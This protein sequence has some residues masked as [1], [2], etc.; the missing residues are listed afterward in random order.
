MEFVADS[1]QVDCVT[2]FSFLRG[3]SHAEELIERAAALGYC[4]LA[5]TDECSIAGVARAHVAAKESGLQ[6]IVGTEIR[7]EDGMKVVLL[8]TDRRSYGAISSLITT[9]RRRAPKGTYSLGRK[10]LESVAGTGALMLWVPSENP[11]L[12]EALWIKARFPGSAWIA[13]ELHCG[14]N[15]RSRLDSFKRLSEEAK[16]PLVAAGD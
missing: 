2:N 10:D 16:L 9:G 8:A 1:P 5:I 7:L 11:A 3:A 6:L 4:A 14:P 13:A 15:D 12:E